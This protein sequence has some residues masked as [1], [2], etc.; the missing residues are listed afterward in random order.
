[1]SNSLEKISHPEGEG[2]SPMPKYMYSDIEFDCDPQKDPQSKQKFALRNSL[3]N[4]YDDL[5]FKINFVSAFLPSKR[6]FQT[7]GLAA[8]LTFTEDNVSAHQKPTLLHRPPTA[9]DFYTGV[10]LTQRLWEQRALWMIEE[11]YRRRAGF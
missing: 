7:L 3:R 2:V 1:M 9:A 4:I 6:F 10:S 5:R 8:V 11:S